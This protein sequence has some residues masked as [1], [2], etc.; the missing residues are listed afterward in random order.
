MR[1][2]NRIAALFCAFFLLLPLFS[3]QSVSAMSLSD[4]RAKTAAFLADSRFQNDAPWGNRTPYLSTW[5]SVGCCAYAYDYAAYVFGMVPAPAKYVYTASPAEIRTGDIVYGHY[6][7]NSGT[8][9][10]HWFVVLKT[11]GNGALSTCEGNWSSKVRVTD[12]GYRIENG[13]LL[14]SNWGERE[15]RI[16]KIYHF[17]LTGTEPAGNV[18]SLS[19]H[20]GEGKIPSSVIG[21]SYT[22]LTGVYFRTSPATSAGAIR[23]LP[24]GTRFVVWEGAENYVEDGTYRWA[25]T[26]VDGVTGWTALGELYGETYSQRGEP[27]YDGAYYEK[28]GVIFSNAAGAP[29]W[30]SLLSG[31]KTVL[32]TAEAFGLLSENGDFAG[33]SLAPGGAVL[34]RAGEE[35]LPETAVPALLQGNVSLELY[36]VF[37]RKLVLPFSRGDID[38]DGEI[39]SDDRT[40]LARHL[41]HWGGKYESV[42]VSAA[43]ID[44]DG[45]I[46]SD[47]RTILA[48]YLAHW[49]G[50][51]DSY[52]N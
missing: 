21:Y 33:W 42:P 41:A 31:E 14:F 1:R 26:T 16:E 30:M 44:G 12:E 39:T 36:P 22:T 6:T 51:Y 40:I 35:I 10:E 19:F 23:A 38:G 17:D 5:G 8:E 9:G 27:V 25:K 50:P 32:P 29:F 37:Q 18:L 15:F 4:Y 45:E 28:D 48:R 2:K 49:G 3:F 46:T 7:T 43:D 47:D 24:K 52:F 20:T 11:L 13:K 34:F